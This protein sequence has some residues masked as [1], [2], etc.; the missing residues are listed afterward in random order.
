MAKTRGG[1]GRDFFSLMSDNLPM[2]EKASAASMIRISDIE[3][4]KDQPRKNFD[5]EA[6]DALA[7]SI[8][9]CVLLCHVYSFHF[10]AVGRNGRD[11]PV[12]QRARCPFQW[13]LPEVQGF[14]SSGKSRSYRRWA[15]RG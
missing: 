5:R 15:R 1:L 12:V 8:G 4:K 10:L 14:P 9:V 6:L 3:P 2:G 11:V 13:E 7:E